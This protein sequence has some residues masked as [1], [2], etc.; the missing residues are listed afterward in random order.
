[1]LPDLGTSSR[2]LSARISLS[3]GV[4]VH[5]ASRLPPSDFLPVAR[6]F[7]LPGGVIADRQ[8]LWTVSASVVKDQPDQPL[9]DGAIPCRNSQPVA[10]R[11]AHRLGL[12]AGFRVAVPFRVRVVHVAVATL[13]MLTALVQRFQAGFGYLFSGRICGRFQ[14]ELA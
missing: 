10:A 11:R 5:P 8:F 14:P 12:S 3:A 13:S 2:S 7:R 6:P 1:M 9:S 4:S